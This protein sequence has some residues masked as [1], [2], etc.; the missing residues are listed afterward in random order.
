[1][2]KMTVGELRD[3]LEGVDNDVEIIIA[4]QPHYPL[5][6]DAGAMLVDISGEDFDL[7]CPENED[8]DESEIVFH[9]KQFFVIYE[10]GG[11]EYLSGEVCNLLGW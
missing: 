9:K 11:Q 7:S 4:H 10:S 1:M 3:L 8:E 5:Q 2:S 6:F